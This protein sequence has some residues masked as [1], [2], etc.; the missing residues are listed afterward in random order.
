MEDTNCD[1][2]QKFLNKNNVIKTN[3]N[4]RSESRNTSTSN[5]FYKQESLNSLSKEKLIVNYNIKQ[6]FI[7][8]NKKI[9][10]KNKEFSTTDGKYR[11]TAH[12]HASTDFKFSDKSI[13]MTSSNNSYI[14]H[15]FLNN[16]NNNY[17]NQKYTQ[18][19]I[20]EE[21]QLKLET[22]NCNGNSLIN[23]SSSN[24]DINTQTTSQ[25]YFQTGN[26][27][28]N[29][30]NR[31]NINPNNTA[32]IIHHKKVTS[33]ILAYNNF[34]KSNKMKINNDY[35]SSIKNGIKTL[36]TSSY[37]SLN[38]N[39]IVKKNNTSFLNNQSISTQKYIK[40]SI[41][42]SSGETPISFSKLNEE[43]TKMKSAKNPI[44][45]RTGSQK[46]NKPEPDLFKIKDIKILNPNNHP[47]KSDNV[48]MINKIFD[49]KKKSYS[50]VAKNEEL[51][52]MCQKN[53]V[54]GCKS[55]MTKDKYKTSSSQNIPSEE[56]VDSN[57]KLFILISI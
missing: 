51:I 2:I 9:S 29:A 7:Q 18:S 43:S 37:K 8:G 33:N 13:D 44:K 28:E 39:D 54:N 19:K 20:T 45:S 46:Y 47:I 12:T 30:N 27:K 38:R 49:Q 1:N 4:V 32:G 35:S 3:S 10:H 17:N 56:N 50:E 34:N 23:L 25:S 14:S 55:I 21:M 41:Y 52:E 22:N 36:N 6:S 31:N 26:I 11:R 40:S 53:Q 16:R 48:N 15:S 57:I 5:N 42:L 24:T